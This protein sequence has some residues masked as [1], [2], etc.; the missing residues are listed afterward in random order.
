MDQQKNTR[1]RQKFGRGLIDFEGLAGFVVVIL[2]IF[3][4]LLWLLYK[5]ALIVVPAL[6][7]AVVFLAF[8]FIPFHLA[9]TATVQSRASYRIS[10]LLSELRTLESAHAPREQCWVLE[11]RVKESVQAQLNSLW[12]EQ[13]RLHKRPQDHATREALKAVGRQ[14]DELR[15]RFVVVPETDRSERFVRL[16]LENDAI[17]TLVQNP[18]MGLAVAF[19][20]LTG[21]T[22]I[23]AA[24]INLTLELFG[25]KS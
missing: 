2:L 11:S 19:V 10:H 23:M 22:T 13:E 17:R 1:P 24:V 20:T 16:H 7:L 15:R 3:A 4:L 8:L 14:M 18:R 21:L 12:E 5:F 25:E 9:S 6:A